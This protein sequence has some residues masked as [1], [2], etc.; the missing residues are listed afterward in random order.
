[1][2][3]DAGK[4]NPG[5]LKGPQKAAI[6]LLAMGEDFA[7][8]FFKKL[9]EKSIKEIGKYM[10]EINHIP[11]EV[12]N[13]VMDEFL[14]NFEN[15]LSVHV[16]G[17]VFL[18]QVISKS[19]DG[20][21][22]REICKSIGKEVDKAPFD[23]LAF[24]PGER[25][26]NIL[27]GEHPQTVALILSYLP[28]GK[29][30]EILAHFPE[31]TQSEIA[32]RIARIGPV[33]DEVVRE[34]DEVIRKELAAMG[35]PAKKLDGVEKLA[36]IL[37]ELDRTSEEVILSSIE[38]EDNDLA[39]LVRKRM[40]VFEDLL[41]VD[42][43][44]FREILQNVDKTTLAKALKTASEEMKAK[45]FGNLSERAA[46]MLREDMEVMGP[47]RLKDVEESQQ[48]ILK[49]AKKLESDGRVAFAGKNKEDVFV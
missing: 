11:S 45:I 28:E 24:V 46:E 2:N 16:S 3:T 49:A 47:V 40:F 9:D 32:V 20:G 36:G 33:E 48:S 37:N 12:M 4:G 27:K 21:R 34:L 17:R 39:E 1:M 23:D 25:L 22:A 15:D 38:S 35:G 13:G 14:S 30:A 6:F 44:G 18:E 41:Q 26:F 31:A 7:S 19:L 42:D 10:S 29:S 8:S 43:K 5:R